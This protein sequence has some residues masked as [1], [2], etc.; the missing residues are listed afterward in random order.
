MAARV[1]GKFITIEGLDGCGKS[2]QLGKLAAVLRARGFEVVLT[3]E[4]GGTPAGETIRGLLLDSRTAGLAPMAELALMFASRAQHLHEVILPALAAG[5]FVLCDRFTDS[6]EAYQGGGRKVGIEPVHQL[7]QIL[8]H[9]IQPDLTLLMDSE[10]SASVARAHRRNTAASGP[11]DEN[12]F[13]QESRAFFERVRNAYLAIAKREP[14]R[15]VLLD[16][17]R[18]VETVHSEIV[19]AV[20]TRLL[21]TAKTA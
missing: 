2:T 20:C 17:R 7:H 8:C 1:R 19:E 11:H 6:T 12:R 4:P 9:G 16:A 5:H 15:V 10:V 21:R 13:E 14:E 18:P 3:R